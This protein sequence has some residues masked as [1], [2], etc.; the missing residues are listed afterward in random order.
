MTPHV[1]STMPHAASLGPQIN[2]RIMKI[3][4]RKSGRL[5]LTHSTQ[6]SDGHLCSQVTVIGYRKCPLIACTCLTIGLKELV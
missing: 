3:C 1:L 4:L 5:A 2:T 6:L